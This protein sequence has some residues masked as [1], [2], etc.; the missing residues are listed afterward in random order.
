M[1]TFKTAKRISNCYVEPGI[2]NLVKGLGIFGGIVVVHS[3][4]VVLRHMLVCPSHLKSDKPPWPTKVAN[5]CLEAFW[6]VLRGLL[7]HSK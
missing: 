4:N 6:G 3:N 7:G 5:I 1:M 2:Q